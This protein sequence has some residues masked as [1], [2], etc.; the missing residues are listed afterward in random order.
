MASG[1]ESEMTP[2]ECGNGSAN[3]HTDGKGFF[4]KIAAHLLLHSV[5]KMEWKYPHTF[6]GIQTEPDHLGRSHIRV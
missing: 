1:C 2:E 6:G 5:P 3:K 4:L